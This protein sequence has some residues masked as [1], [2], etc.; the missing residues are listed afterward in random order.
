MSMLI[1]KY[2]QLTKTSTKLSEIE[3]FFVII[4]YGR[5]YCRC[6]EFFTFSTTSLKRC[7]DLLQN[8]CECPLLPHT[9]LFESGCYPYFL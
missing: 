1:N 8:F 7:T 3:I 4:L 2:C 6:Y 9:G 5:V